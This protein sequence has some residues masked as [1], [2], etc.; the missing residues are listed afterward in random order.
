[1]ITVVL[2]RGSK[3]TESPATASPID[4][5][6]AYFN[7]QNAWDYCWM[8]A[9]YFLAKPT[10]AD[11]KRTKLS[12]FTKLIAPGQLITWQF[13]TFTADG[14]PAGRGGDILSVAV[15]GPS[16]LRPKVYDLLNGT[17]ITVLSLMDEGMYTADVSMR[18]QACRAYA[19]CN[20]NDTYQPIIPIKRLEFFVKKKTENK[21]P[22]S[23]RR[24]LIGSGRWVDTSLIKNSP[25]HPLLDGQYVWR[26][27]KDPLLPF[28]TSRL[29]NRWIYFIGDSLSEHSLDELLEMVLAPECSSDGS[30]IEDRDESTGGTISSIRK[31]SSSTKDEKSSCSSPVHVLINRYD[32]TEMKK[33]WK[34]DGMQLY[35]CPALNLTVTFVFYP[36]SF[37]VGGFKS[38]RFPLVDEATNSIHASANVTF[39]IHEWSTFLVQGMQRHPEI[40]QY[41]TPDAVIFNFGLHYAT[42]LDPPLY[43]ILLRHMFMRLREEFPNNS[44]T[45]L[46]W[47]ST[48]WTHFEKEKL[49]AKWNCRTPVRTQI[50][51]EISNKLVIALGIESIDFEELTAARSDATPDNRHYSHGNVRATYNNLLL[52]KLNACFALREESR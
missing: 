24:Q 52:N 20:V 26:P 7:L 22:E 32:G 29:R 31:I 17:Y 18:W 3:S 44:K 28:P 34:R 37:P 1:M 6:A 51:N 10:L 11:A 13:D 38:T 46:L 19:F 14:R 39:K 47:R 15:Q 9:A 35:Y 8:N 4:Y 49:V 40:P 36:D 25:Q 42:P 30:S 45:V 43:E 12:G 48:A 50:M 5:L 27:F 23:S 16:L 2:K 41:S 33:Q 21:N